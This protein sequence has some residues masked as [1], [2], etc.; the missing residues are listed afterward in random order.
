GAPRAAL[1]GAGVPAG[2]AGRER[3]AGG[4]GRRLPAGLRR[5]AR[6]LRRRPGCVRPGAQPRARARSL[7]PA[8]L[9]RREPRATPGAGV[10]RPRRAQGGLGDR[11]MSEGGSS[12]APLMKRG[13]CR[14]GV[15]APAPPPPRRRPR[16]VLR[17]PAPPQ[18][19]AAGLRAPA[20]VCLPVDVCRLQ[21][22]FVQRA[23][24]VV[25]LDELVHALERGA[26]LPPRAL[27]ITFDDGYADNYR[28][29]LPVLRA[30]GL[31]ATIYVATGAV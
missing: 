8:L 28:L 10:A 13:L 16:G 26:Q 5:T 11:A 24:R 15:R 7:H 2:P 21:M 9:L 20:D 19:R 18:R 22:A 27:V 25:S 1:A 6:H 29:G 31:P 4:A 3:R 12:F 17:A 23:Y 30:L 14:S